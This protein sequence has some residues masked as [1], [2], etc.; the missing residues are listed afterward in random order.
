MVV[1]LVDLTASA[2]AVLFSMVELGAVFL[3][4]V[5]LVKVCLVLN[6]IEKKITVTEWAFWNFPPIWSSLELEVKEIKYAEL[7]RTPY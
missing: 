5:S 6:K 1:A 4:A 7:I 3:P 2:V